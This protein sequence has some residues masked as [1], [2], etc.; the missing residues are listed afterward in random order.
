M[1]KECKAVQR[2]VRGADTKI[3]EFAERHMLSGHVPFLKL[4]KPAHN[5]CRIN[6]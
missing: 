1:G 3:L 4:L 5:I 6:K 2:Y